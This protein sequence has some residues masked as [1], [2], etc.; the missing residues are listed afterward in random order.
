MHEQ[1]SSRNFEDIGNGIY[2]SAAAIA[3][4]EIEIDGHVYFRFLDYLWLPNPTHLLT[5]E[6]IIS[7]NRFR[8]ERY[9]NDAQFGYHQRYCDLISKFIHRA[10]HASILEV[11]CGRFPIARHMK[12]KL[13]YTCI[14]LDQDCIAANNREGFQSYKL[15]EFLCVE[16]EQQYQLFVA[17]FVFQFAI[18]PELVEAIGKATPNGDGL[19]NIPTKVQDLRR[20]RL[21]S[22]R[23]I[24]FTVTPLPEPYWMSQADQPFIATRNGSR[25]QL[26][27]DIWTGLT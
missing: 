17:M 25:A 13:K 23:D 2:K 26:L 9:K 22:F 21:N 3:D 12:R 15:D 8:E 6:Q 5:A 20:K 18:A 24:G 27:I 11:G 4:K 10:E 19:F 7:I 1:Y 14:D 16:R